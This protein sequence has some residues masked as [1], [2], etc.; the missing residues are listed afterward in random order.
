[1]GIA[2]VPLQMAGL[3]SSRDKRYRSVGGAL[4]FAFLLS[5]A[6]CASS[7]ETDVSDV[8]PL[9]G[10]PAYDAAFSLVDG[11]SV[12]QR[13]A[14]YIAVA[15]SLAD[16][17]RVQSAVDQ[18]QY[19]LSV[20]DAASL[21]EQERIRLQTRAVVAWQA[22]SARDETRSATVQER[23]I[24]LLDAVVRSGDPDLQSSVFRRLF[25][26]QLQ[27]PNADETTLRRTLDVA[28]LIDV[29]PVRAEV[30]VGAAEEMEGQ[31]E[32]LAL[33][34]LVQQAIATVPALDDS[35]LAA[36]LS[37]RL[38]LLSLVLDRGNDASTLLS[39]VVRRSEAGLIVDV[40]DYNRLQ[41]IVAS[42]VSLRRSDA[43]QSVLANV[44]PQSARALAHG[45]WA[46]EAWAAEDL[47]LAR[48]AFD[49]ADRLAA[50]LSDPETAAI[51][52]SALVRMRATV[53]ERWDPSDAVVDLLDDI[54]LSTV[55]G[56]TREMV[57]VDVSIAYLLSGRP[58]LVDRLRGLIATGDEYGRITIRVAENLVRFGRDETAAQYL[59]SLATLPPPRIGDEITPTLRAA[60]VWY[61]LEEYDR[62]IT[63]VLSADEETVAGF[64]ATVPA[65]HTIN[66]ATRNRLNRRVAGEMP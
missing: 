24:D 37:A 33:N 17:G 60:R 34:P 38:A 54:R 59:S 7:P 46:I 19:V 66:P 50:G 61:N 4:F 39:R 64:L 3:C 55:S 23:T 35:L 22:V 47:S 9:T 1:M 40:T 11:L 16:G 13:V 53:D 51:V 30:L 14:V 12:S 18:L 63:A 36:D 21:D 28:Y 15:Q 20:M 32:R 57:L 42:L 29:D 49:D 31:D 62:A 8:P 52:R 58:Q 25:T 44:A 48:T 65:S 5:V 10:I 6:G 2:Y 56:A 41:R 45:W 27:N 43:L 26:A